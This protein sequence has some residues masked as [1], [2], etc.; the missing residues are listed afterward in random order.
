MASVDMYPYAVQAAQALHWN[1]DVILA[2][3]ELETGHFTSPVFKADNNFAGIKWNSPARN[4]GATGPGRAANDGGHYAH[5]PTL[6]AGVQG[7][8]DFVKANPRYSN[9][10]STLDPRQEAVL[11]QKD[12]WATDPNYANL[13][14]SMIGKGH[15]GATASVGD[16]GSGSG[17]LPATPT[18]SG[19]SASANAFPKGND[20]IGIIDKS[21]SLQGFD[22]MH[23]FNSITQDVGAIALRTVLV[24]IGLILFIFGLVAIVEKVT[25][26]AP[27][28]APVPIPV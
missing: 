3:W 11:L 23:P 21:L 4:P 10:S 20:V 14:M 13:I 18:S 19:G 24:L 15:A 28:P 16:S 5:Y 2:Q 22:I 27:K 7:Y 26:A 25:P 6:A 8:I 17:S 12:G 9:V 1:P